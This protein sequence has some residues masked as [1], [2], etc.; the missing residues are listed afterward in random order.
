MGGIV[1]KWIFIVITVLVIGGGAA[2]YIFLKKDAKKSETTQNSSTQS[3]STTLPA[4]TKTVT[5]LIN[6]NKSLSTAAA[7]MKS[8]GLDQAL[9]GTGPFTVLMAT[10]DAYKLLPAGTIERLMKLENMEQLK[11]ILNYQI[12]PGKI[13]ANQFVSGQKI[14]TQNGQELTVELTDG[15]VAFIDAKG[16]KAVIIKADINA[17]N[18]IVHTVDAVLL[19]Q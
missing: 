12:I 3:S 6:E 19:P 5:A 15:K 1:K 7:A 18:G 13:T 10:N 2:G 16:G 4:G 14:K 9:E 11:N 8:A 17:S